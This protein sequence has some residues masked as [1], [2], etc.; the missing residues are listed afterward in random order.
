[1]KR[2]V[3]WVLGVWRVLWR[4][5]P[6]VTALEAAR[7]DSPPIPDY[8]PIPN[9][10][11]PQP[12]PEL[13]PEPEPEPGPKP[14]GDHEEGEEGGSRDNFSTFSQML[15][16]LDD[17]FV[18]IKRLKKDDQDSYDLF[19]T[20]GGTLM[21][22]GLEA[23]T[24]LE[25]FVAGGANLPGF[26]LVAFGGSERPSDSAETVFPKLIYGQRLKRT[27]VVQATSLPIYNVIFYYLWDK[28]GKARSTPMELTVGVGEDG[29]IIPLKILVKRTHRVGNLKR[30]VTF[31]TTEMD[32]QPILY[33]WAR[34]TNRPPD[35]LGG[36]VAWAL[37]AAMSSEN[38]V[39]V[40]IEK[41]GVAARFSIDMERVPQF[42]RKCEKNIGGKRVFH[43]VRVHERKIRGEIQ[44]VR[45]H[46]R[47]VRQ[48]EVSGYKVNIS[49]PGLHHSPVRDFRAVAEI[50]DGATPK[51][52]VGM[53]ELGSAIK[54]IVESR[55]PNNMRALTRGYLN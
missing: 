29:R 3:K 18:Y 38:G 52:L 39:S 4:R 54:T 6:V 13:K 10:P 34:K 27:W 41:D 8:N 49:V 24:A 37:N 44:P 21:P 2:I 16:H 1:M 22:C 23:S 35:Q 20:V 17:Y 26:F 47:G 30:G 25:P 48:F 53:V 45:M 42:F 31:R 5:H 7:P 40:R 9:E 51:N 50:V 36:V 46:F 12:E 55:K 11:A 43:A 14:H 15:E 32:Y 33:D 28:K 19:S